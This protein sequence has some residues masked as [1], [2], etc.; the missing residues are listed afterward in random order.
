MKWGCVSRGRDWWREKRELQAWLG[1]RGNVLRLGGGN[2]EKGIN[3]AWLDGKWEV[4]FKL[5]EGRKV[6]GFRLGRGEEGVVGLLGK[7]GEIQA[8]WGK[9]GGVEGRG[10]ERE[11]LLRKEGRRGGRK[12]T[13][14]GERA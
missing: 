10:N 3:Q 1:E 7:R 5:T 13:R 14:Q 4:G 11:G 9:K 2:N 8:W 12:R 6:G